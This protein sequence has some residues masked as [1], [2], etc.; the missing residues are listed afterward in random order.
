[1]CATAGVSLL[2]KSPY[3]MRFFHSGRG[4]Y[5]DFTTF[6]K[7]SDMTEMGDSTIPCLSLIHIFSQEQLVK[8]IYVHKSSVAR[9][10][11]LLEQNGFITRSACPSDRRQLLVYPTE[12]A[13]RVRC[14]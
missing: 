13:L 9:Q 8:E 1:M 7:Y 5:N 10:L 2:P 11:A 3:F 12:K 4:H 6:E 14:V